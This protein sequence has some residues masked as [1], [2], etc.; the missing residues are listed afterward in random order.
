MRRRALLAGLVAMTSTLA[1]T[2][3]PAWSAG[4]APADTVLEWF[5]VSASVIPPSTRQTPQVTNGRAWAIAWIAASRALRGDS[6]SRDFQN[7][8]LAQA[9]HDSLAALVPS[10]TGTLDSALAR[11]L[12]R[13]PAGAARD[14]GVLAGRE[15]AR[16]TLAERAGD[17]LDAA[18]VNTPY[19]PPPAAPGVWRPTPPGEESA[20]QAGQARG[21]TFLLGQADRFRPGSAP[22]LDSAR[23]LRDLAEVRAYGVKDSA[24]R[25]PEQTATATL[26]S[27]A[28][29]SGY[30]QALRAAVAHAGGSP[31]RRAEL[32]AVFHAVTVDAQIAVFDAKYTY[33][34]WRPI[35][36]IREGGDPA[37][38]PLITTPAHPEYPGGH[39]TYAGAAEQV[40]TRLA[41]P[42]TAPFQMTGPA[43]TSRTYT[44]WRQLTRDNV[45]GR[46]WSGIH[47]RFSDES[48]ARLG[49][50]VALWGLPRAQALFR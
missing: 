43:G 40:L 6:R 11:T 30:T 21:R 49:D 20:V 23:Y 2:S 42:R 4:R 14:R 12:D 26:W 39:S 38:E 7:A 24:V 1:G 33:T 22:A 48:G 3:A 31:A 46:V 17:G 32:V 47:F 18:S 16:R 15:Q 19:T 37:W 27:Q 41:G 28:S 44:E 8:A 5:D 9:V 36:A 25:T 34:R 35:T 13:V 50:R 29:L 45:N 10:Q